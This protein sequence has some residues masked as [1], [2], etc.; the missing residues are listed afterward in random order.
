VNTL[1]PQPVAELPWKLLLP[2]MALGAFGSVVLY[3]A[4]GGSF[5]PWAASH[6]ARFCIFLVMAILMSRVPLDIWKEFALPAYVVILLML[7]GVELLGAISGGSQR[8]LDLGIIRLQP[9]E[10]MKLAIVLAVRAILCDILPPGKSALERHL[11]GDDPDRPARC[12]GVI[13]QPDLGTATD[14]YGWRR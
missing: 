9:S 8:W 12:A 6:A 14:D 7:L 1:V 10:L 11:A 5:S 4:A 3:S 2:I 13:L